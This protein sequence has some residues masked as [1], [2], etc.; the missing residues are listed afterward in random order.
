MHA[1]QVYYACA[2][3]KGRHIPSSSVTGTVQYSAEEAY[4]S[5]A[6]PRTR[7]GVDEEKDG[8]GGWFPAFRW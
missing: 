2:V 1:L 8:G 7:G 3:L 4:P 6:A 5:Y